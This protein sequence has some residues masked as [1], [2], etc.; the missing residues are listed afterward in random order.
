MD[1]PPIS[2]H[3]VQNLS[4]AS[5]INQAA[6]PV[7]MKALSI[8]CGGGEQARFLSSRLTPCEKIGIDVDGVCIAGKFKKNRIKTERQV[9]SNLI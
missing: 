5:M 2:T 1:E 9:P 8:F 3:V 7:N 4:L 6:P